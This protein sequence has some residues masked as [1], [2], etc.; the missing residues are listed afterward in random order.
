M[1]KPAA[2]K[3]AAASDMAPQ[4]PEENF[5]KLCRTKPGAKFDDA[6]L[7]SPIKEPI[8]LFE[9]PLPWS[10][11]SGA[12]QHNLTGISIKAFNKDADLGRGG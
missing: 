4:L 8:L 6:A 1:K 7:G 3:Q 11:C 12:S 5:N 2:K 9:T 10:Q